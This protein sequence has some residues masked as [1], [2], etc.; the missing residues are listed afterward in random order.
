MWV[1]L[2][3]FSRILIFSDNSEETDWIVRCELDG[4]GRILLVTEH[5]LEIVSLSVDVYSRHLY[6]ADATHNYIHAVDYF[7]HNR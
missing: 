1:Y 3:L 6:F 4:S 7:G 2:Q 5:V